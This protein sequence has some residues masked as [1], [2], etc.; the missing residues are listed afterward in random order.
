MAQAQE[1]AW[2]AVDTEEEEEEREERQV[3]LGELDAAAFAA[4]LLSGDA[5]WSDFSRW[6]E[7]DGSSPRELLIVFVVLAL[8]EQVGGAMGARWA[9]AHRAGQIGQWRLHGTFR[10]GRL[11]RAAG[12]TDP[13]RAPCCALGP[14]RAPTAAPAMSPSAHSIFVC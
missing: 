2:S 6:A 10:L 9:A 3:A 12:R 4:A 1:A 11:I 13:D 5:S 7:E 8:Q 14:S